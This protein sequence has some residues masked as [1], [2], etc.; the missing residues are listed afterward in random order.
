M[1]RFTDNVVTLDHTRSGNGG[2]GA[3]DKCFYCAGKFGE[4]HD[5]SC[6]CL[7]R[8][9]KCQIVFDLIVPVV[10]SWDK[11]HIEQSWNES[12]WCKDNVQD[13]IRRKLESALK[14]YTDSEKIC[15]C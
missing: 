7:E 4:K 8:A 3:P 14:R 15:L 9:V 11:N 2:C 6:V 10:R 1:S 12:S 5:E 13:D